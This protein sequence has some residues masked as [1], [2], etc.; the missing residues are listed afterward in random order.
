MC[1]CFFLQGVGVTVFS[2]RPPVVFTSL[3]LPPPSLDLQAT[4]AMLS[5]R[6]TPVCDW[7][8]LRNDESLT[9]Q[10]LFKVVPP[11]VISW[12]VTPSKYCCTY[13]KP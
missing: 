12:F 4:V 3:H 5:C 13:H 7:V 11:N 6:V 10:C 8:A 1:M 9:V 2:R